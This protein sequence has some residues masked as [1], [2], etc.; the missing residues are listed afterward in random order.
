MKEVRRATKEGQEDKEKSSASGKPKQQKLKKAFAKQERQK[1][2]QGY[3]LACCTITD[4][5]SGPSALCT[6]PQDMDGGLSRAPGFLDLSLRVIILIAPNA[7][8]LL[9]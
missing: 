4:K 8:S 1:N 3:N 6:C 7:T 2:F 5:F 9:V